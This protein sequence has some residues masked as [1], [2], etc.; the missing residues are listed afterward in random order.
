LAQDFS[1]WSHLRAWSMFVFPAQMVI[2]YALMGAGSLLWKPRPSLYPLV[3]V[4]V[5]GGIVEFVFAVL[6]DAT[7]TARH[8]FFFH[9]ITEVL[10]LCAVGQVLSLASRLLPSLTL[11]RQPVEA[12]ARLSHHLPPERQT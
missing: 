12:A 11:R 1:F 7:E 9:V 5:T 2:F 3:L 6:L 8:L 10:I 4:L